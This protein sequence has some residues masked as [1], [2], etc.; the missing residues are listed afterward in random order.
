VTNLRFALYLAAS[1]VVAMDVREFTRS[2]IATRAGDP[3]PRLWG[4]G[5]IPSAAGCSP[6]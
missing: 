6:G 1:L 4:R 3:T 2:A 5:S